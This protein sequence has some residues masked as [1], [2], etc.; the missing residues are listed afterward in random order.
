MVKTTINLDDE[1][2]AEIVRES[3]EKYGS[4]KNMSKIINQRLGN[5]KS[6]TGKSGKRITFNV[7]EDLASLDADKEIKKGW[8]ARD[9]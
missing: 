9:R 6:D 8:K 3:I 7:R 4:T 1:I 5:K 2:Y